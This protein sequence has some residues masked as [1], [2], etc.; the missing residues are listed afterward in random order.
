MPVPAS[1]IFEIPP[2]LPRG[3]HRL[4]R[5]EV[6]RSQ[7]A[8]LLAAITRLV[9]AKG[10]AAA[11][12]SETARLAGVSPNVF[13][14][15]F[16]GKQECFLAAYAV[17]AEALLARVFERAAPA[18]GWMRFVEDAA[19]AY[20]ETL[21]AEPDAARA[22]LL[23]MDAAGP[24]ARELREQTFAAFAALLAERHEQIRAQDP[25]LGPLPRRVYLAFALG[26][27]A[28]VCDSLEREP[29]RAL[30]PLVPDI[31]LWLT[32]T[33]YGAARAQGVPG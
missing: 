21:D 15:H 3:P 23:E 20:L 2:T 32:A 28:L 12:V 13:Y 11:T 31:A 26:V 27:R 25:H 17:F 29:E 14:E 6:S 22:F 18:G 9:G 8:R 30:T 10:Y 16:P 24:P 19:R 7:R 5:E 1:A 4:S 33:V